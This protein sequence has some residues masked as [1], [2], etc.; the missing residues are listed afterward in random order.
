[1]TPMSAWCSKAHTFEAMGSALDFP[2][3]QD[4]VCSTALGK[5]DQR[6]HLHGVGGRSPAIKFYSK[7]DKSQA[8]VVTQQEARLA[9]WKN[10][11]CCWRVHRP[12]TD[13]APLILKYLPAA[14]PCRTWMTASSRWPMCLRL[15]RVTPRHVYLHLSSAHARLNENTYV[16]SNDKASNDKASCLFETPAEHLQQLIHTVLSGHSRI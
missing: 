5:K 14:C 2:Y 8:Q 3:S 11:L 9:I 13:R 4:I 15:L 7:S 6:H 16:A 12:F 1:M 10:H